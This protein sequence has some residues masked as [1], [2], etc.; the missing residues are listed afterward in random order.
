MKRVLIFEAIPEEPGGGLWLQLVAAL[1]QLN[2]N[3]EGLTWTALTPDGA[4]KVRLVLS[5]EIK[6]WL[7]GVI[8][9]DTEP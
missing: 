1:L 3:P 7:S 4:L 6:R 2:I 9:Q 5:G 8:A